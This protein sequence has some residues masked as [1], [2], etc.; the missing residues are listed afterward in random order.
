MKW[1]NKLFA[2]GLFALASGS[3]AAQGLTVSGILDSR[4]LM[5]AGAADGPAFSY[6]LEEYA[7][8]RIQA[9]LK[10]KAAFY[11][12]VNLIAAAGTM[13]LPA[14]AQGLAAGE[15]YVAGFELERLY[16]RLNG[17]TLDFDGGLL[18]LPFGYGQVWG[19][20]DFLNPKNPLLPDARPR[21]VLGGG[22]SWY[23]VDSLKLLAFG[24]APRNPLA[25]S[26]EGGL[27]GLSMDKHWK[28]AS[29]QLL[30]AF[31]SPRDFSK[32]GLHRF[33]MSVK[34]DVEV[35]LA[36][37]MLY[38]DNPEA[39]TQV[40][41]LSFSLGGDYS[42][43]DGKLI[44]LAEYLYNGAASSTSI[45][46][47][48]AWAGEHYLYAG[49][50]YLI[51]DYTSLGLALIAG[52]GDIS[53]TP[54]ISAEHETGENWAPDRRTNSSP[55]CPRPAKDW[56]RISAWTPK[57]GCGSKLRKGET[58]FLYKGRIPNHRIRGGWDRA[59]AAIFICFAKL[60]KKSISAQSLARKT[61]DGFGGVLYRTNAN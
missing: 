45:N 55:C 44:V 54:V 18:R 16:F 22:L 17:D 7:N 36:A 52:L 39:E 31:E 48:G 6:G 24:A 9:K 57:S 33:G 32:W 5:S 53:F 28:K 12:A 21:A 47:G 4:L 20:S 37:D 23:P 1:Y 3:L 59:F 25:Q 49:A 46:A 13:A 41:G 42:F 58:K 29:L 60:N 11:G 35:G 56:E 15:N 8:I 61:G 38:T 19:P 14:L 26:G 50:T 40:D 27:A 43:A 30:Y 34:A 10:D 51:S 2:A